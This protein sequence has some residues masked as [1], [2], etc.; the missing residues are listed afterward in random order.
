MKIDW[1]ELK[2]DH[3]ELVLR[4]A[5]VSE[6]QEHRDPD[7]LGEPLEQ[8]IARVKQRWADASKS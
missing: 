7:P 4:H 8:T 2:G 6:R 5:L 1:D 3:K